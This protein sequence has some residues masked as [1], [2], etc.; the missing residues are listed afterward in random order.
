MAH[1]FY[2]Q[3]YTKDP[4]LSHDL[5]DWNF[6]KLTPSQLEWHNREVSA[7]EIKATFSHMGAHKAPGPDGL[8]ACFFQK[9][10]H[11]AGEVVTA[12]VHK[13]FQSGDVPE[14]LNESVICLLPKHDHL[15]YIS[16]F[17]PI[18]LSNV[19][20]KA[21]SKVVAA[22]LKTLMDSLTGV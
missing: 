8:P 15:E 10:W 17:R 3:L 18:C 22:R 16:Q 14:D 1:T 12:F 6:P 20:I 21:V 11:I 4:S 13:V 9:Y 19:I 2:V 7:P 5:D